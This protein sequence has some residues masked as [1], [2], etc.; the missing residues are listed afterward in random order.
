MGNC[1][2]GVVIF[3]HGMHHQLWHSENL[4]INFDTTFGPSEP[5]L[6]P[7]EYLNAGEQGGGSCPG[8]SW[9]RLSCDV[10]LGWPRRPDSR[11]HPPTRY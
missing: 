5:L 10:A 6:L 2:D 1:K 3:I 7:P 9:L 11:C 4:D 8:L